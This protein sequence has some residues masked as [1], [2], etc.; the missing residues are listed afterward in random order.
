MINRVLVALIMVSMILVANLQVYSSQLEQRIILEGWIIVPAVEG[1]SRGNLINITVTVIFPGSGNIRVTGELGEYNVDEI[2][3]KSMVMAFMTGSML[4]GYYWR[5]FDVIIKIMTREEISGPSGS[6]AIALL[7][8]IMLSAMSNAS[9]ESFAVTG[10]ISPDGLSSR[11]G[12]VDIKCRVAQGR[13]LTLILPLSNIQDIPPTC[14]SRIPTTGVLEAYS[15]IT[16]FPEMMLNVSYSLPVN[17]NRVM[18]RASQAFIEESLKLVNMLPENYRVNLNINQS[19]SRAYALL[20]SNPYAS[21][22]LAF[23]VYVTTIQAFYSYQIDSNGLNW[24]RSE[25]LILNNELSKLK[26]EL[27]SKPRSGSIY[28]LEFLATAY[29]RLADAN[30]SLITSGRLINERANSNDIAYYLGYSKARIDSIKIWIEAA[31]AVRDDKPVIGEGD[32]KKLA[33]AYG[34]YVEAA[35]SYATV[36]VDYII[37][38]YR[39]VNANNLRLYLENIRSLG[40]Q[41]K[42]EASRGNYLASIGFYREAFSRSLSTLFTPPDV[43]ERGLVDYYIKEL[44]RIQSLLTVQSSTRGLVSGLAPAYIDYSVVRYRYGDYEGS[45]RMMQEAVA[46][47]I[48]W[49]MM[50]LLKPVT[51]LMRETPI[52]ME[53]SSGGQVVGGNLRSYILITTLILAAFTIGLLSSLVIILRVLRKEPTA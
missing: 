20:G 36:L 24:A 2:T 46:S 26:S 11:V 3:R 53:V 23:T 25:L 12:G 51:P 38:N 35:I 39:P 50:I 5:L 44:A 14:T 6:F 17:F 52:L 28:Y 29:T 10:A 7:S 42:K 27:D 8:Y 45:L 19:L 40:E 32:V 30:S 18:S 48:L 33:L 34:D 13:G 9:I 43:V 4:A 31:D 37:R 16:G 49:S 47:T 1:R 22:S 15:K 21:A 41:A